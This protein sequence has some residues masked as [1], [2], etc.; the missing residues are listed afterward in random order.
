M[1]T[2]L[3]MTGL[4]LCVGGWLLTGIALANDYWKVSSHS[5]NVIISNRQYENLWHSCAENSAG[6]STCRDFESMLALPAFMQAC[7]ALMITPLLLG[8]PATIASTL[9]VKCIQTSR[10]SDQ[11]KDKIA[12]TGGCLF[13]LA[14]VSTLTAVSWYAHQVVQEF[15][16]PFFGSK[17]FELGPGLY[18]GWGA[19]FLSIVGGVFLCCAGKRAVSGKP[20]S[21]FYSAAGQGQKIYRA[22][23]TSEAGTSKGYV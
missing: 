3:E 17:R 4:M 11:D 9:G 20:R 7:R 18:M 22:A 8:L 6:I 5:G 16:N 14:G 12:L 15:Y 2:M 1:S 13:I 23:A 19:A 21:G 10:T